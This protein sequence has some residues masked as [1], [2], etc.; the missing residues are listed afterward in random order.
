MELISVLAF[1]EKSVK[2]DA[3]PE[4]ERGR[5]AIAEIERIRPSTKGMLE[6]VGAHSW[7]K[8]PWSRGC[9]YQL[10]PGQAVAW[11]REMGK[12]HLGLHFAGEHLRQ[13]E[14]GMEAAME[15]GER[16]AREVGERLAG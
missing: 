3:M 7:E 2:L 11:T 8:A 15:S 1:S 10:V 16:T 9:S 14:V 12:P 4:A 5:F 13:L 6:F